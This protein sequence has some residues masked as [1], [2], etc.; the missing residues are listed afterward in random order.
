MSF[1]KKNKNW[2]DFGFTLDVSVFVLELKEGLIQCFVFPKF[3]GFSKIGFET[4]KFCLF[5][6]ELPKNCFDTLWKI[7]MAPTNQPFGEEK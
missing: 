4:S 5:P 6:V 3:G 1:P 2:T 7:N